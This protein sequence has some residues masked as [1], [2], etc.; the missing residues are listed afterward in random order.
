MT[1]SLATISHGES[2]WD[3]EI[4]ANF[5]AMNADSGWITPALLAPFD[6][7]LQYKVT[8]QGISFRGYFFPRTYVNHTS[9]RVTLFPVNGIKDFGENKALIAEQDNGNY[10][11]IAFASDGTFWLVSA[12]GNGNNA[13]HLDGNFVI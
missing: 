10:A 3:G 1:V 5:K 2:N 13:V 12:S 9:A 11:T 7:K 4:N 6:G 8:A